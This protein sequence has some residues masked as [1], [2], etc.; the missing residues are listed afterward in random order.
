MSE[1]SFLDQVREEIRLAVERLGYNENVY[2]YLR[3]PRRTLEVHIPII[4]DDGR[5]ETFLA[6]RSQHVAVLGPYKGGIRIHEQV[7][8]GEVE[9]LATLMTLKN[10]VLDLPYGGAKG[11][12]IADATALTVNEKERLC[13][14]YVRGLRTMVGPKFDIPAPDVGTDAKA[15]SWMLDEYLKMTHDID[16][17]A[18]TGKKTNIG[19]M[20]GRAD[21]TGLG[22]AFA[23]REACQRLN[24]DLSKARVAIQGFGNVGQGAAKS[25]VRLGAQVVAV[26]DARGGVYNPNGLNLWALLEH[27]AQFGTVAGFVGTDPITNAELFHLDVDVLVPAALENQ[28]T[29][30]N[31]PHI[32]AR[33]VAEGA[34]GPTSPEGADILFDRGIQVIPDILANG[35]GVTVSYFEWVQGQQGGIRWPLSEVEHRLDLYMSNSFRF[36]WNMAQKHGCSMRDAAYMHGVDRLAHGMLERGWLKSL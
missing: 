19:G 7:T 32:R 22:V 33:I 6:Y 36:V 27:A 5:L 34:N 23:V 1:V 3:N 11:G 25:L 9:A 12:I 10:S 13:R 29:A 31:A 30:Q 14:G 15:I 17:S 35:G 21:A 26:T 4:M 2:K 28:I 8:K 16:F 20:E 18:F 24:I